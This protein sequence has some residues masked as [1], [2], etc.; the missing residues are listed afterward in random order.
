MTRD[1]RFRPAT[2]DHR[3]QLSFLQS[4]FCAFC[5]FLE[6]L[7]VYFQRFTANKSHATACS[8]WARATTAVTR[9]SSE[10]RGRQQCSSIDCRLV[11][12]FISTQDFIL[13]LGQNTNFQVLLQSPRSF[14]LQVKIECFKR[15]YRELFTL[16]RVLIC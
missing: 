12:R 10:C 8:S 11:C 15:L 13:Q 5:F 9:Y 7:C 6:A 4:R 16:R 14:S 2:S 3:C 1:V